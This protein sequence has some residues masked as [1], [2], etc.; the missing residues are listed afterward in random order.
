MYRHARSQ[1][2]RQERVRAAAYQGPG[3]VAAPQDV[4]Q[5]QLAAVPGARALSAHPV[6][7]AILCVPLLFV[8]AGRT[9][10]RGRATGTAAAA[11]RRLRRRWRRW[12]QQQQPPRV[13][14]IPGQ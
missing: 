10:R 2:R 6:A 11:I 5:P 1:E 13:S 9:A 8:P 4:Q 3:P 7:G 12:R 14:H